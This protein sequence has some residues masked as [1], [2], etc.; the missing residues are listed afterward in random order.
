MKT[1]VQKV[2][3]PTTARKLWD[4]F[5]D[6]KK[7]AA[8]TGGAATGGK[9]VGDRFTAWDDY[10][11]GRHLILAPGRL[12]VQAWRTGQFHKSD[13][14]SVLTLTF[15]EDRGGTLLTMVH[16]AVPDHKA[17]SFKKGWKEH[18]WRPILTYLKR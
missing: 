16:A 15:E 14:D 5:V 4:I 6:A 3:F 18:Y 13:P 11:T 12:I 8:A 9:K 7:H 1:I 2:R 17:E 10:I